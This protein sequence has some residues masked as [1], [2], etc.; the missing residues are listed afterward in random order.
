MFSWY[1]GLIFLFGHDLEFLIF[2]SA[3][4]LFSRMLASRNESI[5]E[6]PNYAST[7]LTGCS[8]L[9]ALVL[10]S[11]GKL[12]HILM[13]IWNFNELEYSW[14]VNASVLTSNAEALSALLRLDYWR[15][16]LVLGLSVGIKLL[17][18][19]GYTYVDA[20]FPVI[21]F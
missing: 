20:N 14:L 6:Y 18:Q 10:S 19:T 4:S 3:V 8:I 7:I 2:Y 5:K 11:F 9:L 12:V 15:A 13:L 16:Y 1:L 21:L 17:F